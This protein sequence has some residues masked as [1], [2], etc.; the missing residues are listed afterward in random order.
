M[1][2]WDNEIIQA[3][4]NARASGQSMFDNPYLRSE[5]LPAQ[6]GISLEVWQSRHDAWHHGYEM[7]DMVR[8]NKGETRYI[9]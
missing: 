2:Y 3:G 5:E 6:S 9:L 8:M 4:A 7:E 1:A